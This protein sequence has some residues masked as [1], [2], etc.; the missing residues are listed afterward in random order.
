[1]LLLS[2]WLTFVVYPSYVIFHV[3]HATEQAIA[4]FTIRALPFAFGPWAMLRLVS[5]SILLW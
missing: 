4:L 2:L 3:V 1:M 5:C